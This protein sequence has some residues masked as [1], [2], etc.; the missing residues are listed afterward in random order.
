MLILSDRHRAQLLNR[1][2]TELQA[3]ALARVL[4]QPCY[5]VF[6]GQYNYLAAHD[7][8]DRFDGDECRIVYTALPFT[9]EIGRLAAHVKR[10]FAVASMDEYTVTC[11]GDC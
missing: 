4:G 8:L 6:D 9:E 7:E 3:D 5:V 2:T 1:A 10:R 11:T